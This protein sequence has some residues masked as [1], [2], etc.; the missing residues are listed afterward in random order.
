MRPD[1]LT[2]LCLVETAEIREPG[3]DRLN[4]LEK[5][6]ILVD[7]SQRRIMAFTREVFLEMMYRPI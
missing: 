5:K 6:L 4:R 2:E 3:H 1:L 7:R